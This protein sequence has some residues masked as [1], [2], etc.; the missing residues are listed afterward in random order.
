MDRVSGGSRPPA[1]PKSRTSARA[2]AGARSLGEGRPLRRGE[3]PGAIFV[4]PQ[5]SRSSAKAVA[6]AL[7]CEVV[8][9][10]P[11]ARDYLENMRRMAALV[12]EGLAGERGANAPAED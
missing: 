3:G 5:F 11:L 2:S 9:L 8:P 10:D 6:R 12:V 7:G 1:R 4:Q